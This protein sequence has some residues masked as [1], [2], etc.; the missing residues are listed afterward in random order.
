L[1]CKWM[2]RVGP[3]IHIG[4]TVGGGLSQG[5]APTLGLLAPVAL[6]GVYKGLRND[7]DRREFIASGAAAGPLTRKIKI[8]TQ[9][10]WC[11][12]RR[13]C[14]GGAVPRRGRRIVFQPPD[15]TPPAP[16]PARIN[17][18]LTPPPPYPQAPLRRH[19]RHDRHRQRQLFQSRVHGG[20][21]R[22]QPRRDGG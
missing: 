21:Q 20:R 17:L 14:W 22:P 12:V 10:R 11:G 7:I 9:R 16:P 4:G 8:T 18:V 5:A 15:V 2:T 19:L 1:F 6:K 13:S 3:M